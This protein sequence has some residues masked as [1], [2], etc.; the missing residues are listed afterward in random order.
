MVLTV[1]VTPDLIERLARVLDRDEAVDPLPA[2]ARAMAHTGP[3]DV[4]DW[5]EDVAIGLDTSAL[6][7]LGDSSRADVVDYLALKHE[8]PVIIPG[9]VVSRILEQRH[10]RDRD[11]VR[12]TP[13]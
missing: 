7:R 8:A 3:E 13:A 2:L 9:Q 12:L 1:A 6:F 10:R 11:A 5:P 4:S